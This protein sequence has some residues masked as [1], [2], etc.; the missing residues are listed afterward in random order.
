MIAA[1]SS[2]DTRRLRGCGLRRHWIARAGLAAIGSRH[3]RI[4]RVK[5]DD[6]S[7]NSRW[8]VD[9]DTTASLLSRHSAIVAPSTSIAATGKAGASARSLIA[10]HR[11]PRFSGDTC[12]A[13]LSNN[14][15]TV[16]LEGNLRTCAA[17]APLT[18]RTSSTV[19]Q[20][21]ASALVSK[22]LVSVCPR[23]RALARQALPRFVMDA[24]RHRWTN[25]AQNCTYLS[26][27]N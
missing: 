13:Y 18:I 26:D 20:A 10:S 17:V 25:G 19:T 15:A 5:T 16:R 1:R 2:S 21:A 22:V 23:R 4:A 7:V 12:F 24:M 8:T 27:R 9:A 14:S 11:A 6:I 3:S